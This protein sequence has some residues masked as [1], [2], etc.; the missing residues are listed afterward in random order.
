[1]GAPPEL[2]RKGME[3]VLAP[4]A[5]DD[6]FGLAI[7]DALSYSRSV[8]GAPRADLILPPY[9]EFNSALYNLKGKTVV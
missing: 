1:M 8:L 4:N 3:H 6:E 5:S 9:V 2:I 7:A